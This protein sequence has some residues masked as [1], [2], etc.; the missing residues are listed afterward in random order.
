MTRDDQTMD[1]ATWI[2]TFGAVLGV[3][4]PSED[5]VDVVLALAAEAAHAS[6]RTAAPLACWMAARAGLDP[7]QALEAARQV[8]RDTPDVP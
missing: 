5:E 2:E 4:T 6:E 7:N 1:Q 8:L 3:P